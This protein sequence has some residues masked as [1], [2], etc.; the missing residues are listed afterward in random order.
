MLKINEFKNNTEPA[1]GSDEIVQVLS[2]D[3][4]GLK[5]LYSATIIKS[6]ETKLGHSICDHF[7]IITGT[8]TGGLIALALGMR[9]TGEEIQNFYIKK[10]NIIFP[11]R[12]IRTLVNK[13]RWFLIPK[14][15]NRVLKQVIQ[16]FF[17]TENDQPLLKDSHKRLL[18]PTYLAGKSI[19][20]LLKTPHTSRYKS[21]WKMP[22]W[23]V[24]LATSAAPTY[25]PSFRYNNKT[26][27]DGGIW[28][29]NPSL[30]GMVEAKDLGAR[31]ENIRIMNIGTTFSN[32]S[33]LY[34]YP[35]TK[36][37][38]TIRIRR[39]GVISWGT[40][41]LSSIMQANS[42]ATPNM[43]I[44][45]LLSP[46]NFIHIND[47]LNSG[48]MDL[49]KIDAEYLIELGEIAAEESFQKVKSFFDHDSKEYKPNLEALSG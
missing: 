25:L 27:L 11:N 19:P 43:Y 29:N 17:L 36:M 46:G 47:Q 38:S 8:S 49:D 41:I 9:K 23:A 39:G 3:G 15:S 13:I 34:F 48:E 5:G 7:D 33:N 45:Q 20:R 6:F 42:Y 4:G 12:G 40:K 18:I 21:D 22:I 44:H 1:F 26:Y 30:V 24:G 28:A 32:D 2:L 35:L 14:Y 10:G 37:I 16:N 31:I